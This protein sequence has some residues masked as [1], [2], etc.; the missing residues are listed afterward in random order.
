[1]PIPK[2]RHWRAPLPIGAGAILI[3]ASWIAWC[4]GVLAYGWINPGDVT[5]WRDTMHFIFATVLGAPF[6]LGGDLTSVPATV[7]S[8]AVAAG[9]YLVVAWPL[10]RRRSS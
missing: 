9:I 2:P 10:R 4:G 1:M 3:V 5:L 8:F 6:P 7:V